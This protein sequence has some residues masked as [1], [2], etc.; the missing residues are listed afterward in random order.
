MG[1]RQGPTG[2]EGRP[3]RARRRSPRIPVWTSAPQILM[4]TRVMW[5]GGG[6]AQHRLWFS[7]TGAQEEV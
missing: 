6:P 5:G 7:R 1:L 3:G 2:V 4:C